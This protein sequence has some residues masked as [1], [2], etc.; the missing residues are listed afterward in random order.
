[1]FPIKKTALRSSVP[2][3]I[4]LFLT[5]TLSSQQIIKGTITDQSGLAAVGVTVQIKNHNLGTATDVDGNFQFNSTFHQV[6]IY[7]PFPVSD[8][9]RLTR[10]L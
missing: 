10:H 4:F 9:K 8:I 3:M 2:L 5:C 7:W 6:I 1:M